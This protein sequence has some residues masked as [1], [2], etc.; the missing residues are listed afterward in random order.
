M[1]KTVIFLVVALLGLSATSFADPGR[2]GGSEQAWCRGQ[3]MG[4]GPGMGA[5]KVMHSGFGMHDGTPGI[6]MLLL[7]AD[8]LELTEAQ[9][10]KLQAMMGDFQMER[11]DADA[12][13]K[14]AEIEL[15]TLMMADDA[16]DADVMA[17][18]DKV[19]DLKAELRK[20][21]Y[22]HR[23]EVKSVL[24]SEQIDKL[25]DLRKE[26]RREWRGRFSG[27]DEEREV[28]IRKRIHRGI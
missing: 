3:G 20:M 8:E 11:V 21:Q 24:T 22:L 4:P 6:R 18:I 13:L 2:R 25:D 15:K 10:K 19:A 9:Q 12:D 5:G 26:R 23:K 28:K 14:K 1:K 17:A 7:A 16:R 27:D